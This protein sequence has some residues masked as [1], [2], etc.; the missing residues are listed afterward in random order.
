M[1][2][3]WLSCDNLSL[4]I[5]TVVS[6]AQTNVVRPTLSADQACINCPLQEVET[7]LKRAEQPL[8]SQD[9]ILSIP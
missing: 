8:S 6:T 2:F 1:G 7:V 9:S 4:K 3:D 5:R